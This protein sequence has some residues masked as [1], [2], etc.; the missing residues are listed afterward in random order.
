V[1]GSI[2][3]YVRP[4]FKP[5]LIAEMARQ[6]RDFIRE[7]AQANCGR[8]EKVR[9]GGGTSSSHSGSPYELGTGC[10]AGCLPHWFE[11]CER[12]TIHVVAS[13]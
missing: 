1:F 7:I 11:Q 3:S 2:E 8:L 10:E 9:S 4:G 13:N 5:D 6:N 12:R